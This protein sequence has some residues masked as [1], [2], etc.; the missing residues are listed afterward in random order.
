MYIVKVSKVHPLIATFTFLLISAAW[1]CK[2]TRVGRE[3]GQNGATPLHPTTKHSPWST[4]CDTSTFDWDQRERGHGA[5]W[6]WSE[7]TTQQFINIG[8]IFFEIHKYFSG[9]AS[10]SI[11]VNKTKLCL[12]LSRSFT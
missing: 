7:E 3:W 11:S 9:W 4:P 6:T 10:R 1:S 5:K 8:K 2:S 12:P